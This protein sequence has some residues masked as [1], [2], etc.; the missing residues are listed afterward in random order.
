MFE[1]YPIW[2]VVPFLSMVHP[3]YCLSR[4]IFDLH[5]QIQYS[6]STWS[7]SHIWII[8]L[9]MLWFLDPIHYDECSS[10]NLYL[11]CV[12][13]HWWI[14]PSCSVF[15]CCLWKHKLLIRINSSAIYYSQISLGSVRM[16]DDTMCSPKLWPP[17]E[18][19]D[20]SHWQ[21]HLLYVQ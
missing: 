9:L 10:F 5:S 7:I 12:E 17:R 20:W 3:I 14:V 11:P 21:A 15:G 18:A 19:P 16:G 4:V 13:I 8:V 1:C 2:Y 6:E